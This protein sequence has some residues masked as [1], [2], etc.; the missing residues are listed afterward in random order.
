MI[1]ELALVQSPYSLVLEFTH[2][3]QLLHKVGDSLIF[4]IDTGTREVKG[5]VSHKS[6]LLGS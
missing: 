1:S 5:Q 3:V 6:S 2:D 4:L